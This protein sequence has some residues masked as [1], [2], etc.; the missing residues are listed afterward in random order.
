VAH[1]NAVTLV[2]DLTTS[3][4]LHAPGLVSVLI[5]LERQLEAADA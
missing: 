1:S 5:H 3:A 2:G 4:Q